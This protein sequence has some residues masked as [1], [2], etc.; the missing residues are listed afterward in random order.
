MSYKSFRSWL[1]KEG[2]DIFGF[3]TDLGFVRKKPEEDKP[4]D[5]I[6][7]T[8]IIDE[9]MRLPPLENGK[10]PV[11]LFED[12]VQWGKYNG[13][14]KLDIS[15]LGSYKGIF[16]RLIKD[17]QGEHTWVCKRVFSLVETEHDSNEINIAHKLYDIAKDIDKSGTEVAAPDFP[18][19]E[20]VALK[21][22]ESNRRK[23]PAYC[24]FP[25]GMRKMSENYYKSY[26]EYRGHGVETPGHG[27]AEQFDID[28]Y[29]DKNRG[30]MRC[31]GYDIDSDMRQHTWQV[32][33]S[34]WDEFFAP[35]QPVD[36]ICKAINT[37]F[38]TY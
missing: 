14:I 8:E 1:L 27:R 4:I 7:S 31:W 10:S 6:S 32:A 15:P 18:E 5:P 16:R 29:W 19:F 20:K 22:H 21:I 23:F 35:G 37:A 34:E 12:V 13:A 9:L 25:M 38:M 2:R 28:I 24:M 17:L 33:P 36:E 11:K 30:L 26:F 3:E